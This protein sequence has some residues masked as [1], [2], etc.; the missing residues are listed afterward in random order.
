MKGFTLV[1]VMVILIIVAVVGTL[2][3]GGIDYA[4]QD[5][6]SMTVKIL[7]KDI[8]H[9]YDPSTKTTKTYYEV[10]TDRVSFSDVGRSKYNQLVIGKT[11]EITIKYFLGD[12]RL[13]SFR[14]VE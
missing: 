12:P 1:E 13:V 14:R 10:D 7:D 9:R 4:K 3:V 2:V 6:Q 8:D 5:A 11:Y